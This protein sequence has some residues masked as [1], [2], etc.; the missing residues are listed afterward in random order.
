M[1]VRIIPDIYGWNYNIAKDLYQVN[2]AEIFKQHIRTVTASSPGHMSAQRHWWRE[3]YIGI[4]ADNRT[5]VDSGEVN[6]MDKK[7]KYR[8]EHSFRLIQSGK[9][10]GTDTF[11]L[12]TC[13]QFRK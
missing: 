1:T 8:N 7:V 11:L 6:Q 3:V 10:A 9:R 4:L 5:D 13:L 12:F 2:A